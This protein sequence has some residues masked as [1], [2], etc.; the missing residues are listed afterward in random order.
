MSIDDDFK[1]YHSEDLEL[2]DNFLHAEAGEHYGKSYA[3]RGS[4]KLTVF[5]S[6][7]AL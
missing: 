1:K 7:Y 4:K 3:F 5:G 2:L 6:S